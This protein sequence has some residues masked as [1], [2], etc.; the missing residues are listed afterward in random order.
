MK[1]GNVVVGECGVHLGKEQLGGWDR[2]FIWRFLNMG[3][4]RT[5]E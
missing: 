3:T 4:I 2:I 5:E 1:C